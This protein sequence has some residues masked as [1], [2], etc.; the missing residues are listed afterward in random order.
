MTSHEPPPLGHRPTCPGGPVET[1]AS[2][3]V[4]AGDVRVLVHRCTECGATR[5]RTERAGG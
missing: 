5:L 1:T 4:L 3:V 2:A